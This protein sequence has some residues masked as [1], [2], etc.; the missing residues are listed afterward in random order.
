MHP[1]QRAIHGGQVAPERGRRRQ[2]MATHLRRARASD[3]HRLGLE[4]EP[5][6]TV[7]WRGSSVTVSGSKRTGC[8]GSG[9]RTS[10]TSTSG[11]RSDSTSSGMR[12]CWLSAPP[13]K[14]RPS[15]ASE[16]YRAHAWHR[17][18]WSRTE[19]RQCN[20]Q[21][22]VGCGCSVAAIVKGCRTSARARRNSTVRPDLR[23]GVGQAS[24]EETA[25]RAAGGA[26]SRRSYGDSIRASR[27]CWSMPV[28]N[29]P[30][31][32]LPVNLSASMNDVRAV[33][34]SPSPCQQRPKTQRCP[35]G[36]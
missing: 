33:S 8:G 2:E 19:C 34:R 21:P 17:L 30:P 7:S 27:A 10:R 13:V 20:G 14:A 12:T 26:S 23:A 5:H 15:R 1:L 32:P 16:A 36:G 29:V 28:V 11:G 4:H 24:R 3:E 18:L 25:A 9:R 22:T 31:R 35:A 6:G